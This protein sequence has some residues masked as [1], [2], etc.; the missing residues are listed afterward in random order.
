MPRG[1]I[2]LN[3]PR[4]DVPKIP[5]IIVSGSLFK[6]SWPEWKRYLFP[7]DKEMNMFSSQGHPSS[8]NKKSVSDASG[9]LPLVRLVDLQAGILQYDKYVFKNISFKLWID[10]DRYRIY[11]DNGKLIGGLTIPK[12][13][14][15]G[16]AHLDFK[17]FQW[18]FDI[19]RSYVD[20]VNETR[21]NTAAAAVDA[22]VNAAGNSFSPK[23]LPS[24]DGKIG[25]FYYKKHS[26]GQV[27]IDA[28]RQKNGLLIKKLTTNAPYFNSQLSGSWI[29]KGHRQ[30]STLK[31]NIRTENTGITAKEWGITDMLAGGKGIFSFDLQ[32]SA[33]LLPP[34]LSKSNGSMSLKVTH[35]RIVNL[36][37]DAQQKM[38]LGKLLNLLSLQ[39][40]PRRLALDFSDLTK[41]G[42]SYDVLKVGFKL[43]H[44]RATT[45]NGYLN[46]PVADVSVK[47]ALDF[48]RSYYDLILDVRPHLTST[49]PIIATIAGTPIAGAITWLV[50]K[51][52]VGPIVGRMARKVI[53]MKGYLDRPDVPK[54]KVTG[55]NG[56]KNN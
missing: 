53:H 50:N 9:N 24:I 17:R 33:P 27:V 4:A 43:R 31:G 19:D 26:I 41:K 18:P 25:D 1:R 22:D 2:R 29:V 54:V 49:L 37:K 40:L 21:S 20:S 48:S 30:Y 7:K 6:L 12:D 39:T 47:G 23:S 35:G 51:A 15:R 11:V 10:K 34:G 16:V 32:W 8:S 28:V 36:G 45:D 56:D 52:V 5:G 38:G 42:Y 46:G 55:Y 14:P 13:Y 3:A 44:G